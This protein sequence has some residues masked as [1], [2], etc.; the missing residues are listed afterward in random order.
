VNCSLAILW[1]A[2][3]S[4]SEQLGSHVR[5]EK[6]MS[7]P[8][9]PVVEREHHATRTL[10]H[11][12]CSG[13]PFPIW[14][15]HVSYCR[16][17]TEPSWHPDP[18]GRNHYRWWDGANWTD[19]VSNNGQTSVDPIQAVAPP[20]A[21]APVAQATV[22]Q[23]PVAQQPVVPPVPTQPAAFQP[24]APLP[25]LPGAG[26][27]PAG[28]DAAPPKKRNLLKWIIPVVA[29]VAVG[30]VLFF[31]FGGSD[32][33]SSGAKF[34]VTEVELDKGTSVATLTFNLKEG[35]VIRVRIEPLDSDL[36]TRAAIVATT[37]VAKAFAASA[38]QAFE[39]DGLT[40]V[41]S[42][43]TDTSDVFSDS[44]LGDLSRSVA[45]QSIDVGSAG[46]ADADFFVAF[47]DGAYSIVVGS[48]DSTTGGKVRIIVEKLDKSV[49]IGNLNGFSDFDQ[50][51]SDESDF[52]S[53]SDFFSSQD[54]FNP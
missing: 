11:I 22:A 13:A 31:V 19:S 12:V 28:G 51:T 5:P 1:V 43:F 20:A 35:D 30:A 33:D 49:D 25:P 48:F 53:D 52:F 54:T 47:A 34:G 40:D 36:D 18:T 17:M 8:V 3:F 2:P 50:F 24:S 4:E 21:Q 7:K 42:F 15:S 23:A 10:C 27:A 32:D 46:E 6:L 37:Q 9:S 39:T 16:C 29:V 41:E 26:G 44:D 45:V 38:E 14:G